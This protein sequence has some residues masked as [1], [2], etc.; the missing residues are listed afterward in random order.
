M[1]EQGDLDLLEHKTLKNGDVFVFYRVKK[2]AS[3]A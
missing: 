1:K 3:D 2:T